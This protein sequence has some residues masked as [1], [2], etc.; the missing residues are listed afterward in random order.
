MLGSSNVVD[1]RVL[2]VERGHYNSSGFIAGGASG[3]RAIWRSDRKS[4][5]CLLETKSPPRR[6]PIC[7]TVCV[8]I[9]NHLGRPSFVPSSLEGTT[10]NA[11]YL[12]AHGISRIIP[13]N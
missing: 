2:I 7:I 6:P 5:A 3:R 13:L 1:Q 4:R 9:R 10:S 8:V 12:D 11:F